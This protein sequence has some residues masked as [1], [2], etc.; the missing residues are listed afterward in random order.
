VSASS[1]T[2]RKKRKE[3]KKNIGAIIGIALGLVTTCICCIGLCILVKRRRAKEAQ[4]VAVV[5][6]PVGSV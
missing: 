3:R 5:V 1:S 6:K 2:T 4:V